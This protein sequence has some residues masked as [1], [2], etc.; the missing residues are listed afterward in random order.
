MSMGILILFSYLLSV[1]ISRYLDIVVQ[2]HKDPIHYKGHIVYGLWFI[3]VCNLIFPLLDYLGHEISCRRMDCKHNK[4]I[5][6]FFVGRDY[7]TKEERQA[8]KE[9]DEF[10]KFKDKHDGIRDMK[11]PKN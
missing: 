3:P 4:F 6:W 1:L 11:E 2:L 7:Q 8:N 5:N 9:L 10:W